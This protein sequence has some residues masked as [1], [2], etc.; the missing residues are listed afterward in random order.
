MKKLLL[1]LLLVTLAFSS[2][3]PAYALTPYRT[4]TLGVN[5]ELVETQTAYDPVRTMTR[6]GDESL[7]T[8]SDLRMGPDGNLYIA[9]TG[10]KRILVVTT[11]GE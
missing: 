2:F 6:F 9:D 10:N 1:V 4:F 5:G 8:P 3:L 11:M 7:K